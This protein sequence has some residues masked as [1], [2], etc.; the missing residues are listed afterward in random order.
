M[1][2]RADRSSSICNVQC[3]K[4]AIAR[5]SRQNYLCA[6]RRLRSAW[7]F[8]QSFLS[9]FLVAKDPNLLLADNE[10]SDQTGLIWV[11]AGHTG[12]F[13]G[14]VVLRLKC[15]EC[16]KV[17]NQQVKYMNCNKK[18]PTKWPGRPVKTKISLGIRPVWSESS[19]SAWRILGSSLI[20]C[21][22]KIDQ[23]GWM[24]R[25]VWGLAGCMSFGWFCHIMAQYWLEY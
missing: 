15:A 16:K 22:A 4:W 25:L 20:V 18:K 19:L 7:A 9:I 5:Q 12:H 2:I 23:T 6:Q 3:V 1:L 10:A 14:F 11:L 17:M 24:P 21:T 13:V 8:T